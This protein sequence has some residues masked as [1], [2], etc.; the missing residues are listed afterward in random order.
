[1][2][3]EQSLPEG[4]REKCELFEKF[5]FKEPIEMI[6]F[7]HVTKEALVLENGVIYKGQ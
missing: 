1:M 2:I 6:D 3:N 7:E 4:M 5:V